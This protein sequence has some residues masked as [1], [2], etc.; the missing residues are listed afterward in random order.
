MGTT[1][2]IQNL[3]KSGGYAQPAIISGTQKTGQGKAA[4]LNR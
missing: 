2:T 1:M 3:L 4:I